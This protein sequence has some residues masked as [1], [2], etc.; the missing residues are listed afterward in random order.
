MS[1]H[2]RTRGQVHVCLN[3]KGS[4]TVCFGGLNIPHLLRR[5]GGIK[6]EGTEKSMAEWNPA[7]IERFQLTLAEEKKKGG[8]GF[9]NIP[10]PPA[11]LARPPGQSAEPFR[12]PACLPA[13]LTP[14]FLR[15]WNY[16]TFTA[17]SHSSPPPLSVFPSRSTP[18]WPVVFYSWNSASCVFFP[19]P[20]NLF[21]NVKPCTFFVFL[22]NLWGIKIYWNVAS[23]SEGTLLNMGYFKKYEK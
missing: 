9:Q 10:H 21:E 14:F 6:D 22:K 23:S 20:E 5:E 19:P 18:R 2:A 15:E 13:C 4:S 1:V 12:P 8:G 7:V 16:A 17:S 3:R 11:P